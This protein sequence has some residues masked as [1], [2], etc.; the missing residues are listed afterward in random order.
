M[1]AWRGWLWLRWACGAD[2]GRL[3][4][5]LLMA[6]LGLFLALGR[7]NPFYYLLYLVAPGFDLFRALELDD[8][9]H[10]G[11]G[12]VGRRGADGLLQGLSQGADRSMSPL[13]PPD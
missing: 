3:A 6:G 4:F 7:W 12:G 2:G 9:L 5:G 8:A 13:P 10:A 11:H 1:W